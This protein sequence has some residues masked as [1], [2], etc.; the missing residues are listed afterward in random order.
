MKYPRT[1]LK[2]LAILGPMAITVSSW[3]IEPAQAWNSYDWCNYYHYDARCPYAYPYPNG[4]LFFFGDGDR[5]FHHRFDDDFDHHRH[6]RD[7][8]HHFNHGGSGHGGMEHG[9]GH[10]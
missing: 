8:D 10:R 7:S 3:A 1:L 6:D 2:G 4:G 9:G 5:R